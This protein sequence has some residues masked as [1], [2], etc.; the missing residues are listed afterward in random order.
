[1]DTWRAR[2]RDGAMLRVLLA[3]HVAAGHGPA[4]RPKDFVE[5]D[6]FSGSSFYF[7]RPIVHPATNTL[8]NNAHFVNM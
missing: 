6:R 1:M 8:A 2:K 5:R 3:G 7:L 4:L